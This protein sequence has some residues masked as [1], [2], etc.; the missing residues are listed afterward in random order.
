M[1]QVEQ[2]ETGLYVEVDGQ[3]YRG[4]L[5]EEGTTILSAYAYRT[6]DERECADVTWSG[7]TPSG[8]C[9]CTLEQD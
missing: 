7:E 2:D 6:I 5:P 9:S 3:K 1:S 4:E 8:E